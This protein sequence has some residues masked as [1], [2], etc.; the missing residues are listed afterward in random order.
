MRDEVDRLDEY[1]ESLLAERSAQGIQAESQEELRTFQMAARLK[2]ARPGAGEPRREFLQ[3]LAAR[4]SAQAHRPAGMGRRQL[5]LSAMGSL[6]AGLLAGIGLDRLIS[7]QPSP[8]EEW[9]S[10]KLVGRGGQWQEVATLDQ[11]PPGAV[12]RFQAGPIQGYLLNRGGKIYAL[13]AMCTHMGCLLDW[14]PEEEEFYCPCHGAAFRADGEM[15]PG[16]YKLALPNL[17][18]IE[19]K[20]VG[21]KIRV[22]TV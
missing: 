12:L 7:R 10:W 9:K 22:W 6:A 21:G 11:L 14:E 8:E 20:V 2:A 3:T 4:L 18:P 17:W 16:S 13:S 19:V 5:I 15:V 1:I